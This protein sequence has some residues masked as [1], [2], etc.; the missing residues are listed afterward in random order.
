MTKTMALFFSVVLVFSVTGCKT[1]IVN[2]VYNPSPD[3]VYDN[4]IPKSR[5]SLIILQNYDYADYGNVRITEF[6]G[7][8]VDWRQKLSG[9]YCVSVPAGIHTLGITF[10]RALPPGVADS[11]TSGNV[12]YVER[13]DSQH[14]TF[15]FI[16]AKSY[17]V[18]AIIKR[19]TELRDLE[20][21][22]IG[23]V[24]GKLDHFEFQEAGIYNI[25]IKF[26]DRLPS[27][28][29]S[30]YLV[31]DDLA[32]ARSDVQAISAIRNFVAMGNNAF[33]SRKVAMLSNAAAP[34]GSFDG[35]GTY[36]ILF[37][38]ITSDGTM[39]KIKYASGIKF[40]D[41]EATMSFRIM[42]EITENIQITGEQTELEGIW[43][44]TNRN[45]STYTFRGDTFKME[46]VDGKSGNGGIFSLTDSLIS[47]TISYTI[48]NNLSVETPTRI[49]EMRYLFEDGNLI[50][51]NEG[52][53]NQKWIYEK[54]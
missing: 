46:S 10:R 17:N 41:M 30:L 2:Q 38:P 23:A 5:Q 19:S 39:G 28:S 33:S 20:E 53:P 44:N 16:P 1:L 13:F 11:N 40:D 21:D 22:A 18:K 35:F 36:T 25:T 8:L 6:D 14:V 15:E 48:V 31:K 43:K 52:L 24:F 29:W 4:G 9:A 7:K 47:L 51:W 12:A 42:K 26:T 34:G 37:Q 50:M 27:G 49:V 32:T 54:Q 3:I 45:Q